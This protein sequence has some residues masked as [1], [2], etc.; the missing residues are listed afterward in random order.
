[1]GSLEDVK[2]VIKKLEK[3]EIKGGNKMSKEINDKQLLKFLDSITKLSSIEFLGIVNMLN[4][5]IFEDEE[6]KQ[7]REFEFLISDLID[8]YITLNRT[9]RV[10]LDKIINKALKDGREENGTLAK[11]K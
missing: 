8:E 2:N 1:M 7:P 9:Q 6:L 4:I 10:N 11:N 3:K 5:K